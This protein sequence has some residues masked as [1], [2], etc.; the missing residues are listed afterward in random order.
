MTSRR[1]FHF[2]A[3]I[4]RTFVRLQI[5]ALAALAAVVARGAA[6]SA[7]SPAPRPFRVTLVGTGSPVLS[8]ARSGPS[9]LV[10]AGGQTLLF[11]AG[12]GA[13]QHLDQLGV[14]PGRITAVFLTHLHSD[15][16]VGLP[17]LWLSGWILSRRAVPWELIGPA[18]TAV[19]AQHL[20]E[21]YAFDID[22]R[23]REGGQNPSGGRLAAR[24]VGPG[25]V[26]ERE[27]VKVTAFLVDHGIVAPAL[28]YRIEYGGR[29]V[30]L[31]GDTRFSRDLIAKARGTDLLVHEVAIA[32]VDVSPSAPYYRAFAHHTTPE[33]AAEVFTDARPR[34]AVFSHIVVFGT[35]EEA[36]ILSRTRHAYSGPLL[37]GQDLM[38]IS[39]GD[40]LATPH[41]PAAADRRP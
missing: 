7:Q 11:D 31:S 27:G 20:A 3:A 29:S 36:E 35:S 15:H 16:V 26:Y 41:P 14:A 18:G 25:V 19:M 24:D 33:Q 34:L 9:I 1:I 23:I 17:D 38:S 5:C 2:P 37:L 21:A 28:G 39:V 30:V 40:T 4:G 22:I 13:A 8:A 12:R 10:E 32:P 6:A